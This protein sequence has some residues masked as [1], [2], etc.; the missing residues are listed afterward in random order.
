[1]GGYPVKSGW[2]IPIDYDSVGSLSNAV[3]EGWK[4]RAIWEP[5]SIYEKR[6]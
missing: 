4:L 3:G 6:M 1:M 5:E 2:Y